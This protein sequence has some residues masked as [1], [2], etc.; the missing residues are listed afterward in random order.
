MI[1]RISIN[2]YRYE[3]RIEKTDRYP[4]LLK[5]QRV[6]ANLPLKK[7]YFSLYEKV[8]FENSETVI[9]MDSIRSHSHQLYVET[10]YK[11]CLSGWDDKRYLA[12]DKV[13]TY[14]FGNRNIKY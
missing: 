13:S 8:L 14:A 12:A 1:Y 6:C 4:A 2:L 10:M 5:R 3:Y 7:L 11:K 9:A